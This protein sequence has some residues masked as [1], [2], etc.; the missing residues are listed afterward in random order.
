[1]RLHGAIS[2]KAFKMKLHG[3]TSQKAF[4]FRLILVEVWRFHTVVHC[5]MLNC[6]FWLTWGSRFDLNLQFGSNF[7][8]W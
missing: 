4:V 2:Q 3:A 1:M 5:N 7:A 6:S 8:V